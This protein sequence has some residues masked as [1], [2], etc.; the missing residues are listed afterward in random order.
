[1]NEKKVNN[2]FEHLFKHESSLYD[3]FLTGRTWYAKLF[4]YVFWHQ[5]DMCSSE[6]ILFDMFPPNFSGKLLDVPCGTGVFTKNRYL[7]MQNAKIVCLDYSNEMIERFKNALKGNEEKVQHISF[8]QGD[9]AHLPYEDES[10]DI[11]LSMNGYQCFP[12]KDE[13]LKEMKRVLK[14]GG[15]FVGSAYRKGAYLISDLM[16]KIYDKKGIMNPP[17]ETAAELKA[18][19]EQLFRVEKYQLLGTSAHFCCVKE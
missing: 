12:Q 7:K 13:S 16:V 6:K 9:V 19:L 14:K 4:N 11:V 15:L 5:K 8:C 2:T 17:H 3:D 10:F 18:H 1:M